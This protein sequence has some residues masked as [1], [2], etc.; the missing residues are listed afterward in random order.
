MVAG[1]LIA[2]A[3]TFGFL[4]STA[5]AQGS[6]AS[7][8][9]GDGVVNGGDIG[10]VLSDWGGTCSGTVT[11]VTPLQG[12]TLGGSE[13]TITGTNLGGTLGVQIVGG[14]MC[15]NL[16]VLS[17][18]LVK[19]VTPAGTG[20][21]AV[22]VVNAAGT[23]T[24]PSPYTYVQQ[25]ITSV[26]PPAGIYS[27]GT[28]ITITGTFLNGATGVR[29]GGVACTNVVAVNST[30]VTAVT[31]AGS[32]GSTSVAVTTPKG[33]AT[34][35]NAFT[36]TLTWYTILELNP[37]PAVVTN[38]QL[39]NA[40]TA[41][42]EPWRVRDNETQIE[43][44]LVPGG[45][46]LMG[47][48][49]SN[50]YAGDIDE[51]PTHLVT[52]TNAFYMGR[53]EVTQAQWLAKMGS[54]PS[55]FQGASYPDAASRPVDRVSW[56]TIQGFLTATG[57]QLPTEAQWEYACRAGTTTAFHG[58]TGYLSGT[59]DDTL[60]GNIAWYITNS[61]SQ[62]HAVGGKAAN[63]LGLHDMGGN[64]WE[65]CRDWE[66]AY[67][68]GAQTNPTG[69]AASATFRVRRGGE[70]DGS[71]STKWMRSSSRGYGTPDLETTDTGFRVTR[72]P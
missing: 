72:S 45:T 67:S 40:I 70:W 62:T 61:G 1:A 18:T 15:T 20:V 27:G 68:S 3:M 57:M 43:M 36:Y 25:L 59:N 4:P 35:A 37:N 60:V 52:L 13:I 16:Q 9:N 17:S 30:T 23:A 12:S 56:N 48:T 55:A 34:A 19:A 47:R 63:G 39:R 58:F 51:N 38:S 28:A 50:A 10:A 66:G 33:T 64:V 42:G 5:Q 54:N 49:A 26:Y 41:F 7:D 29:V 11:S 71:T 65:W 44:V 14:G 2:M 21:G 22:I 8:V 24:A 6:C 46:F 53:Y 32:I 69:P 31:G